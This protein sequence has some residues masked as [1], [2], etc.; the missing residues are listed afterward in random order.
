MIVQ[1]Y[2][3]LLFYFLF[4]SYIHFPSLP[5]YNCSIKRVY[6]LDI[7][8]YNITFIIKSINIGIP[9]IKEIIIFLFK[10]ILLNNLF[11]NGCMVESNTVPPIAK[12]LLASQFTLLLIFKK[13]FE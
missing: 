4:F 9:S 13:S 2:L 8:S 6:I 3:L 1:I 7:N 12:F 11:N 10:L 5:Y